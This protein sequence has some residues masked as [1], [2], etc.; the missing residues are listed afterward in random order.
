M[1]R[2][3]N[4]LGWQYNS[5]IDLRDKT[6][7]KG[8]HRTTFNRLVLRHDQLDHKQN[9]LCMQSFKSFMDRNGFEYQD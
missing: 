5:I 1:C 4:K 7:P 3:R 9:M 6:K 2:L 8:M